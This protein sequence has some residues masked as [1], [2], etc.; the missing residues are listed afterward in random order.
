MERDEDDD[1]LDPNNPASSRFP[2]ELVEVAALVVE[3]KVEARIVE[4]D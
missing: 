1:E 2:P 4:V 3:G